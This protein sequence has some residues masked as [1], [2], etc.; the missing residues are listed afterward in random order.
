MNS[1][2]VRVCLLAEVESPVG[3][4]E[5]GEYSGEDDPGED[6]YLLGP[7]GEL[8]EPELEE[9]PPVA[10]GP[11]LHVYLTLVKVGQGHKGTS[12]PPS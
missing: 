3:H 7:G 10:Q 6:V 4:V 11:S 2:N 8:V 1:S 9:V 5:E 12:M